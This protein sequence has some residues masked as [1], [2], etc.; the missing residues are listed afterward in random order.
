M[1]LAIYQKMNK[2]GKPKVAVLGL[3]H[4]LYDRVYPDYIGRQRKQLD[5][6]LSGIEDSID[7]VSR[8]ICFHSTHMEQEI[9]KAKNNEVDALLVLPLCYTPGLMSVPSLLKTDIPLVIWNT[10]ELFEIKVDYNFDTLL[11]NHVIQ[12]TQDVTNILIRGQKIFGMETGHYEDPLVIKK[13]YEWLNAAKTV[14]YARRMRVG[15]LGNPGQDMGDFGVDET[16]MKTKWGPHTIYLNTGRFIE[17]LNSVN[18]R[19][20]DEVVVSDRQVYE[21]DEKLTEQ[22]HRVSIKLE[23]ALREII[24]EKALDAFTMNFT[25]LSD[26][27]R[28]PT[29]PFLGINKM[30]AEGLGYAGE[31]NTTIA[32]LMAEM[33]HMCGSAGFTEAYT[34][35][36]KRNLI[37]MTHMQECNPALARKDRKV[38]LVNKDFWAKG[39][40]P[41][42]GMYFTLEPG[43]VTLVNI[44][45][46]PGGD[47]YYICFEAEIPDIPPLE[48]FDVAHWFIK[49]RG[50]AS[51]LLT[52]FSM[53][54]GNHHMVA[55]PGHCAGMIRKL[56]ILQNFHCIIL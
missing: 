3:S 49:P 26:D 15:L 1:D 39:A 40:G 32:A 30:M 36:F 54:G 44:T 20:I 13:I 46:N 52:W 27:G 14:S 12:G 5:L 23:L 8:T 53:A 17:N 16:L 45:T 11:M 34:V 47:F 38:K 19:N 10:Q 42:A 29:M 48:N 51:E 43:P 31:G 2:T 22:T 4:E 50:D 7:I 25:D 18:E 56:A 6:F 33:W 28:F 21:F 55:V 24:R 35:D 41:Y 9:R 37:F